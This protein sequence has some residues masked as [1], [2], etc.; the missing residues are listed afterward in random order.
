M[1]TKHLNKIEAYQ[2]F[3][4]VMENNLMKWTNTGQFKD[5]YDRFVRN[6]KKLNEL[7]VDAQQDL[8]GLKEKLY[9]SRIE[10][11]TKFTPV[12]NL[13]ELYAQDNNKKGM[14]KK[15]EKISR[16]LDG[17]PDDRLEDRVDEISSIAER[18]MEIDPAT[19][20]GGA[21]LESYGLDLQ[22]IEQL[23][24]EN[25]VFSELKNSLADSR[26]IVKNAHKE[27]N[28]RINENDKLLKRRI[29][30]FMSIYKLNDPVFYKAY[31]DAL[32]NK[33][34][35]TSEENLIQPTPAPAEGKAPPVKAPTRAT[36]KAKPKTTTSRTR[37]TAAT[38]K[39]KATTR[40]VGKTASKASPK[41]P[42]S[43]KTKRASGTAGRRRT[44]TGGGGS[45]KE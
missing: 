40:T 16:R 18:K 31:K 42:A 43:P 32:K 25:M 17:M 27:I 9:K 10:L 34:P 23:K 45:I 37:K 6:L 4:R 14:K 39:A 19:K 41:K 22:L 5:S 30:K 26:E 11:I 24:N 3:Y 38:S 35:G 33:K 21:R 12:L 13:V 1:K 29:S 28:R 8:T 15:I 7:K 36:R 2:N 20:K 44:N